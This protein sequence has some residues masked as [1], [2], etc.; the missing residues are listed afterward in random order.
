MS[1]ITQPLLKYDFSKLT[2][3]T[4]GNLSIEDLVGNNNINLCAGENCDGV[5][6]V[7]KDKLNPLPVYL[8][9][10]IDNVNFKIVSY[11]NN[12]ISGISLKTE[13]TIYMELDLIIP[14]ETTEK[15]GIF[16]IRNNRYH[17]LRLYY[18]NDRIVLTNGGGSEGDIYEN[19]IFINITPATY[20]TLI[21]TGKNGE[22]PKLY[23]DGNEH[24]GDKECP[25][26]VD[27]S[28]TILEIGKFVEGTDDSDIFKFTGKIYSFELYDY[29]IPDSIITNPSKFKEYRLIHTA[30]NKSIKDLN[31][32]D[33][34]VLNELNKEYER[35]MDTKQNIAKK[36]ENYYKYKK[37][38]EDLVF[39]IGFYRN[40]GNILKK[41]TIVVHFVLIA[42]ILIIMVYR[43]A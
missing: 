28:I 40:Y 12:N 32:E 3:G 24:V 26:I 18:I 15:I 8:N 22:K 2:E 25:L 29:V 41:T 4:D 21:L 33:L 27:K 11:L 5:N 17:I 42:I 39:R 36:E 35:Q 34:Y 19:I 43:L 10:D 16:T 23:L 38:N 9:K 31:L 7:H 14:S 30:K 37:G 6:K 1:G 13:F 20:K